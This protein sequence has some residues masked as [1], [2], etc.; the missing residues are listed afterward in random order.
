MRTLRLIAVSALRAFL[1]LQ[2]REEADQR[3]LH[4][5]DQS[6]SR[7]SWAS[8]HI[9]RPSV[10]HRYTPFAAVQYRRKAVG[11]PERRHRIRDGHI[12]GRSRT[13]GRPAR[14]VSP[15]ACQT[16]HAD[17]RRREIH[18]PGLRCRHTHQQFLLWA[19]GPWIR[20]R[21]GR[22]D[23]SPQPKSRTPY[24]VVNLAA[25]AQRPEVQQAFPD[26]QSTLIGAAK[27]EQI[28]GLQLTDKGWEVS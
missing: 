28:V 20:S 19:K 12:S 6:V 25:W 16:L 26:I 22:R 18:T 17:H 2:R 3:N 23:R 7:S 15:A 4:S 21:T 5:S 10:S 11:P 13:N 9:D 1:R 14:T 27:T 24:R 8:L